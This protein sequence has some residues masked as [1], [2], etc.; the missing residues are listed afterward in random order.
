MQYR[1]SASFL[2]C[3]QQLTPAQA[4]RL[5]VAIQRF[6]DAVEARQVPAGLGLKPLQYGY[7]EF[8]IGLSD[9]VVFHRTADLIEFVLVGT[10]DDIKRFL[11]RQ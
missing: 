7:W 8:R 5:E 9:R 6:M 1:R 11:R 10:H 2:R 3:L 4:K